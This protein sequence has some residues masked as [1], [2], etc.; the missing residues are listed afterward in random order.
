[1]NRIRITTTLFV[2]SL[3]LGAGAFWSAAEV[4]SPSFELRLWFLALATFNGVCLRGM[5]DAMV[6][7][8]EVDF[9]E[10]KR[11]AQQKAW[12]EAVKNRKVK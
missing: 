11:T 9:E 1:M 10:S 5:W 7:A 6:K 12:R 3:F 2:L 8:R 4:E